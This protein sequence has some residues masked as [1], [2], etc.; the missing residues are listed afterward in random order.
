MRTF[1][2]QCKIAKSS[3][4]KVRLIK[5]LVA[6]KDGAVV[7]K[8]GPMDRGDRAETDPDPTKE[9]HLRYFIHLCDKQHPRVNPPAFCLEMTTIRLCT[10]TK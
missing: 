9:R 6:M 1:F 5:Y 7:E 4:L 2:G 3:A 10:V 8:E